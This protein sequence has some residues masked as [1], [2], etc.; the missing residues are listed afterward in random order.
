[1]YNEF[2]KAEQEISQAML[3]IRAARTISE[4]NR[5]MVVH[6]PTMLRGMRGSI[7]G[8]SSVRLEAETKGK[9]I[10]AEMLKQIREAAD[11]EL[12]TGLIARARH[13][14][15]LLRGDLGVLYNPSL[16]LLLKASKGL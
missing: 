9:K 15:E 8:L 2:R 4:L 10:I 13:E 11:T 7:P 5:A 1:M 12:K 3:R 16:E 6:I 14:I